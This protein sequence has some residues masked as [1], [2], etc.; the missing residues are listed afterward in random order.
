VPAQPDAAR[1]CKEEGEEEAMD[2]TARLAGFARGRLGRP[3][4]LWASLLGV[5]AV[6]NFGT[7]ILRVSSILPTPKPLDFASYY[8]GAW[9]M[10]QGVSPY[11][12]PANLLQSV[13]QEH[14]LTLAPSPPGSPPAWVWMSQVFTHF[15][16]PVAAWLWLALA[17]VVLVWSTRLLVRVAG[18]SGWKATALLLP[19]TVSFG[20]TFL[21]LT[22][23]QNGLLILLA[24]LLVGRHLAVQRPRTLVAA[25][26]WTVAVA[27]KIYP[28]LWAASLPFL[29]RWRL[30]VSATLVCAA[31][32]TVAAWLHPEANRAYWSSYL[33]E[34][35]EKLRQYASVDDQ[36]LET[37]ITLLARTNSIW[38]TGMDYSVGREK[39]WRAPWE[40]SP[41]AIRAVSLVIAA[42]LAIGVLLVFARAELP[43]H[44]EGLFYLL[45]LFSLV[46]T[47]HIE[48]YNHVLLLPAMAW[49]WGRG[50]RYRSLTVIAYC[51]AGLSRLNHLWAT[52][53]SWP[54]GPLAMG[55]C[56]YAVLVLGGGI[57]YCVTR[58]PAQRASASRTDG[59]A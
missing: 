22:L 51:L 1:R 43:R 36:S 53:L 18:Y 33:S 45:V 10:R 46:P 44:R 27:A 5:G 50:G 30:L 49:L 55:T 2:L 38:F 21:N 37:W 9:A 24:A 17:A 34:R 25:V 56:L 13:S 15:S 35:G 23:G 11:Y 29:K 59:T 19:F 16:F 47:P 40:L 57:A 7:A 58:R 14:G 52:L 3:W 41:G 20:P 31:L 4:W 6:S 28:V 26:V 48:R 8:V 12:W 32:F 39:V 54:F 42:A